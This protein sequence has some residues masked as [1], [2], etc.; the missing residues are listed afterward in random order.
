[1]KGRHL[2]I[3]RFLLEKVDDHPKDLVTLAADHYSVSRQTIL[4]Q[5]KHLVDEELMVAHGVTKARE[6]ALKR[7]VTGATLPIKGLQE[8]V[9]WR[10][11]VRPLLG[12]VKENVLS[13][14]DYGVTEMVNNVIDHSEGGELTL[15]V[16]R[17]AVKV[18]IL[19]SDDGVGIFNKIQR[20]FN[21]LD[22]RHALLELAK[23]KLTSDEKKHSGQ[24]VFFTSRMFDE[25]SI[26]SSTLFF[27]RKNAEDDEW[28]IEVEDAGRGEPG[29]MIS[30]TISYDAKQTVKEVFDWAAGAGGDFGFTKTHVPVKLALYEGEQL[31]SRSQAKRI[32]ARVDKFKEVILDFSG[33]TQIG[34]AFADEMFRVYKRDHPKVRLVPLRTTPEIKEM[35]RHVESDAS[36]LSLFDEGPG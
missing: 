9:V 4:T 11:Q 22:P 18:E 3:R 5:V 34:Q 12:D 20:D 26:T 32:L 36:Q 8:D 30:M 7:H 19:V 14:C 2:V 1:M 23:G 33:V 24:G 31:M 6:Y 17:D 27:H 10:E 35:I 29:T 25:F 21:L 16:R 13:I 15:I 28:L